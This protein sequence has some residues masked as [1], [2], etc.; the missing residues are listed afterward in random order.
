[1]PPQS[2]ADITGVM[3]TRTMSWRASLGLIVAACACVA[4]A[5]DARISVFEQY[6]RA[7][8]FD[9]IKPLVSDVL[10]AQFAYV[11]AHDPQRL[12][13]IL[14]QQ[15]LASYRPRIVEIDNTASFLVLENVAPK[16]SRDTSPQAY[17]LSKQ[18]SGGWTLANRL[19]PD[20][21][22]KTLWTTSF[23]P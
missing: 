1:M 12:P 2:V 3:T 13:Q 6:N 10:A 4:Q 15:Q 22:L 8:T 9:E 14:A 18:A 23:S 5:Q 20:S 19:T 16:S 7:R 21:I 11:A 17:L